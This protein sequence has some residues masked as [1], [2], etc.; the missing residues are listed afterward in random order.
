MQKT[1]VFLDNDFYDAYGCNNCNHGYWEPITKADST[2]AE[3][4]EKS[5]P[6]WNQECQE[7][8][9]SFH[10]SERERLIEKLDKIENLS[11]YAWEQVKRNPEEA[12]Q[13]FKMIYDLSR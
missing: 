2:A 13:L 3:I 5:I 8:M 10:K 12:E 6:V 1:S 4:K 7:D 9:S 11:K